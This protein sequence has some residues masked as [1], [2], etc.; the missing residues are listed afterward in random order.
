MVLDRWL[1]LQWQDME[2]NN[3]INLREVRAWMSKVNFKP[4]NRELRDFFDAVRIK[5][6]KATL[7]GLSPLR[8]R[9]SAR[10]HCGS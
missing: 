2:S 10:W 1:E 7:S 5:P 9:A 4:S 6:R 8:F 3:S